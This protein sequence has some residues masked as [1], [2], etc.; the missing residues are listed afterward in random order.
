MQQVPIGAAAVD[1]E[2][3]AMVVRAC[4]KD[5]ASLWVLVFEIPESIAKTQSPGYVM[6]STAHARR[7]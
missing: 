2:L 5:L 7:A 6:L 4:A 3:G 1:T